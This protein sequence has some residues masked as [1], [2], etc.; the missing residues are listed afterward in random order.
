MQSGRLADAC[1]CVSG[2][3]ISEVPRSEVK[4]LDHWEGLTFNDVVWCL[5]CEHA[6]RWG[7]VRVD[8]EGLIEHGRTFDNG[9]YCRGWHLSTEEQ[10]IAGDD[11]EGWGARPTH[12]P[13][14][15]T[16]GNF[17]PLY[18]PVPQD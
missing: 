11:V 4:L 3:P 6:V 18:P 17:Y 14:R 7:D 13:E 15:L 12:W 16:P 10:F 8:D 2:R 5:T 9:Y 1:R